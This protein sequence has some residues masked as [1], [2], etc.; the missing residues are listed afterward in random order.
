MTPWINSAQWSHPVYLAA[1]ADPEVSIWSQGALRAT[2]RSPPGSR[3]A[4]PA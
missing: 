4:R 3:P 2:V 1:A